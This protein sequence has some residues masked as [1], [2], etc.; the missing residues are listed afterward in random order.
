MRIGFIHLSRALGPQDG[1]HIARGK[2]WGNRAAKIVFYRPWSK[3]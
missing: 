1:R 2:R 3:E